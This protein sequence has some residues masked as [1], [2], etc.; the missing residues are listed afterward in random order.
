[1]RREGIVASRRAGMSVHYHIADPRLPDLI[2][3]MEKIF[4]G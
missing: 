1:M 2:R 4:R 3:D